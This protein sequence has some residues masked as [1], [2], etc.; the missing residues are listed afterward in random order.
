VWGRELKVVLLASASSTLFGRTG[1]WIWH[2]Y[3][4]FRIFQLQL[5][6]TTVHCVQS[7]YII[8]A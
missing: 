1:I 4:G 8:L 5:R 6:T 2:I 7:E 3:T